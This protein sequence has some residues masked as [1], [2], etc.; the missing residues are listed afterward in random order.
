MQDGLATV[1]CKHP[2]LFFRKPSAPLDYLGGKDAKAHFILCDVHMPLM[3]AYDLRKTMQQMGSD[4]FRRPF[5]IRS[6]VMTER[7]IAC[8]PSLHIHHYYIKPYTQEEVVESIRHMLALTDH[9]D[10]H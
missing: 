7:E 1:N 9:L 4:I 2:S 10:L 3:D 5:Y 6:A 8:L